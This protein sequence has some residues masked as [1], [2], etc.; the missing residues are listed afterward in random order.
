MRLRELSRN[1]NNTWMANTCRY[2]VAIQSVHIGDGL[3]NPWYLVPAS[4]NSG[5]VL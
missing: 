2:E 3:W 4:Q 1:S 5:K